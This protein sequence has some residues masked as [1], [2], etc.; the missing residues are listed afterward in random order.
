LIVI[1]GGLGQLAAALEG[2]RKVGQ[3]HIPMIGLAKARGDKEERIFLPS[4]KNP[5]ILRPTSP[6]THLLQRIRDEAHRFAVTYHRKL[7]GKALVSSRLDHIIGVGEIR[8]NSLL[9]RFGSLDKISR[10]T[11][12]ELKQAGLDSKTAQEVRK[13]FIIPHS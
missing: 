4:R 1:D 3:A 6:V 12:E 5:I 8:R 9:R 10:A 7:R 2:L 13:A 11:E